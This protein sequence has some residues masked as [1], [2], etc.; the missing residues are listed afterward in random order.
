MERI[1]GV[2]CLDF[3]NTVNA[4][5]HPTRDDLLTPHDLRAWAGGSGLPLAGPATPADVAAARTLRDQLLLVFVPVLRHDPPDGDAVQ[6]LMAEVAGSTRTPETADPLPGQV[7]LRWPPPLSPSE[8]RSSIAFSAVS[9]LVRGSLLRV[10]GCATCGWFF[11]DTSRNG[12][13]RWCSMQYCGS[14]AKARTYAVKK[15]SSRLGSP[16]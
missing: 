10:K 8:L 2:L 15:R 3:L 9:L 12:T 1:G 16:A 6:W 5:P 14:Q 4:W 11:L 7:D 13:R